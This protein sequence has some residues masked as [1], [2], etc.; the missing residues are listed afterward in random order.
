MAY[1]AY[2]ML[3]PLAIALDHSLFK[4]VRCRFNIRGRRSVSTSRLVLLSVWFVAL[5]WS[6]CHFGVG[7]QS[8]S[9]ALICSFG[10]A[11]LVYRSLSV[12]SCIFKYCICRS[13]IFTY[14]Y[15]LTYAHPIPSG[16]INIYSLTFAHR[17]SL[18]LTS[19]TWSRHILDTHIFHYHNLRVQVVHL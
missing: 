9:V 6:V 10:S 7:F 18:H 19:R 5:P 4:V 8:V 12:R 17:A 11:A 1:A 2:C 3:F 16:L 13:C 15:H 14:L